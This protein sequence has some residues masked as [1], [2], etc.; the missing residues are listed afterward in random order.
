MNIFKRLMSDVKESKYVL[1]NFINQDLTV[2]YKR[3][4]LGFFWSLLNPLATMMISSVVFGSIMR[5]ELKDF[6]VFL[7]AGMLPWGYFGSASDLSGCS[8]INN[9]G[10]IKKIYMP[11]I[12]FPLT[13]VCSQFINMLFSMSALFLFMLVLGAKVT[14]AL[15]F[16]PVAFLIIFLWTFGFSL[17]MATVN[18]Y[19]RDMRYLMSVIMNAWYYITPILYP[20]TAIPEKLRVIFYCN[21]GYYLVDMFRSPIY[22]NVLPDAKNILIAV[23]CALAVFVIGLACFY[24]KE[25]D[26]CFRL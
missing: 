8:I 20:I 7:Y 17:L 19:F 6:V 21:P 11:K 16:L 10:F 26:F 3:S 23:G 1:S 15:L 12:V 9:E 22:Y 5:F 4:V 18:V 25:K 13:T 24:S 2:K 14:P